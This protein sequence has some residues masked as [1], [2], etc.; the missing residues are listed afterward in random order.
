MN[1]GLFPPLLKHILYTQS[2]AGSYRMLINA[3]CCHISCLSIKYGLICTLFSGKGEFCL[4]F[5][6]F[7]HKLERACMKIMIMMSLRIII[8]FP[9]ITIQLWLAW[10]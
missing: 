7:Q 8:L 1:V 3:F 5:F 10:C 2:H 4:F 9:P 6:S